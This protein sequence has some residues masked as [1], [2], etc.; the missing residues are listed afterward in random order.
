VGQSAFEL[1]EK[2]RLA[3]RD[4]DSRVVDTRAKN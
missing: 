2:N 3:L 1:R 4:L